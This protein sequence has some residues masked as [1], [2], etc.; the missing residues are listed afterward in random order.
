MAIEYELRDQFGK[1]ELII[2]CGMTL[3]TVMWAIEG[4]ILFT[5]LAILG[6]IMWIVPAVAKRVTVSW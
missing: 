2:A 5:I 6:F 3:L 4:N 1:I